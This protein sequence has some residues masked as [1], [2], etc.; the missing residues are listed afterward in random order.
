MATNKKTKKDK[1]ANFGDFLLY[2]VDKLDRVINGIMGAQG[3]LSGGLGKNASIEAIIAEYDKLGGLIRTKDGQKVETGTF[4]DFINRKPREDIVLRIAEKKNEAGIKINTEE[5]G[6]EK[7]KFSRKRG[8]K[9][10]VEEEN[11]EE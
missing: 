8:R 6:D 10:K 11:E 7:S 3:R 1:P 9:K 5:I 2:S 4:Y